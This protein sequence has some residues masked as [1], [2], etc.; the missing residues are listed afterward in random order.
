MNSQYLQLPDERKQFLHDILITAIE[1]GIN[2]WAQISATG[3]RDSYQLDDAE[4]D[5]EYGL[6]DLNTIDLG[7]YRAAILRIEVANQIRTTIFEAER[8]YNAG[9]IDVECADV[10]VQ[11]GLFAKIEFS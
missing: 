4:Q 5:E 2:Y 1:G 7:L 8:T 6:L 10:I 11:L 9:A 3:E